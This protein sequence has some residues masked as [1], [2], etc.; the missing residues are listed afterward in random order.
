MKALFIE[1]RKSVVCSNT[2]AD[3]PKIVEVEQSHKG[4]RKYFPK[5]GIISRRSVYIG[6][7]ECNL[8]YLDEE[9]YKD[10]RPM[11]FTKSGRRDLHIYSSLLITCDTLDDN[12]IGIRN[13]WSGLWLFVDPR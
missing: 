11:V 1:K 4:F 3:E 10:D 13:S 6:A 8:Y 7:N 9:E 2:Y 5:G 12:I